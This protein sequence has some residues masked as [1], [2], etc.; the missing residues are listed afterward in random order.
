MAEKCS[1][2][3]RIY[4]NFGLLK[5][6]PCQTC[7][8]AVCKSCY[9]YYKNRY[10]DQQFCCATHK[11]VSYPR[12]TKDIAKGTHGLT[13]YE[14]AYLS[15]LSDQPEA[16]M[17]ASTISYRAG[18]IARIAARKERQRI[19][20]QKRTKKQHKTPSPK[21]RYMPWKFAR[22]IRHLPPNPID[23]PLFAEAEAAVHAFIKGDEMPLTMFFLTKPR[24]S[25]RLFFVPP[26]IYDIGLYC[27]RSEAKFDAILAAF[28]GTAMQR[29]DETILK[30]F[31]WSLGIVA[32]PALAKESKPDC[33]IPSVHP[34]RCAFCAFF[35]VA[36]ELK[37][38]ECAC[39]QHGTSHKVCESCYNRFCGPSASSGCDLEMVQAHAPSVN[40]LSLQR[41]MQRKH[42][43]A[44]NAIHTPCL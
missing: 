28:G 30:E 22:M 35:P 16:E 6:K 14:Y 33:T 18:L 1:A 44:K 5:C 3:D 27:A 12:K 19:K 23:L 13:S 31:K 41:L 38:V 10:A 42:R 8:N 26:L 21:I 29:G 7:H 9:G 37:V 4:K 32:D 43:A 20:N 15:R 34:E 36:L 11:S 39:E 40:L 17:S 24:G 25:E 2:C